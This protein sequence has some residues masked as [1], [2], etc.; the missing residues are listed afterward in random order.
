MSATATIGRALRETGAA[1]KQAGGVEVSSD[2]L[3]YDFS[4][5]IMCMMKCNQP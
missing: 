2:I 5:M 3:I 4:D 1:L